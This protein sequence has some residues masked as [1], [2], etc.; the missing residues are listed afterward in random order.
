MHWREVP[1]SKLNVITD[2]VS[3]T[4]DILLVRILYF[5]NIWKVTDVSMYLPFRPGIMA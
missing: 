2:T 3:I 5:L 1:G 4:R